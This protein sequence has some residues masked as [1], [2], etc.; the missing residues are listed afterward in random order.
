MTDETHKTA[1]LFV[2]L[3]NICRSPIAEGVFRYHVEKAGV[4]NQFLIDSAGCGGWHSGETPDPRAISVAARHG[5]SLNDQRARQIQTADFSN[6]D[7]ILGLDREN[8]RHLQGLSPHDKHARVDLYLD[9][10][11]GL[12]EDVPDPFYGK[13]RDFEAVFQLC[14][15]ASLGL[16]QSLVGV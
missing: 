16:L 8:V 9:R 7:L 2:C 1:I 11:L 4:S 10:A 14:D 5:I 6:F 12:A 3:G 15:R 13:D